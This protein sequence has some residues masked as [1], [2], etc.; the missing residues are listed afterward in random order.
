[1]EEKYVIVTN[2]HFTCFIWLVTNR[3]VYI[4]PTN[5]YFTEKKH[6]TLYKAC[7]T[8]HFTVNC[9]VH[10]A[11]IRSHHWQLSW[12]TYS[13]KKTLPFFWYTFNTIQYTTIHALEHCS[14]RQTVNWCVQKCQIN[15]T[16]ISEALPSLPPLRYTVHLI[17]NCTLQWHVQFTV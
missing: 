2:Y 13:K 9:T 3:W 11:V 8:V 10:L 14:V 4:H 6:F 5:I 1:M 16:I 7:C 17:V 12:L 15:W